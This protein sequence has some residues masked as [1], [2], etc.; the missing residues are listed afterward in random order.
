MSIMKAK[1]V[2]MFRKYRNIKIFNIKVFI[3]KFYSR[4]KQH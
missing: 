3:F 4:N 2:K 1:K